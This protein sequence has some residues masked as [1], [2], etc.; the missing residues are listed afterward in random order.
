MNIH[1]NEVL[2][3]HRTPFEMLRA[4]ADDFNPHDDYVMFNGYGGYGF[5]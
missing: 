4:F 2:C 5:F 3:P 1:I